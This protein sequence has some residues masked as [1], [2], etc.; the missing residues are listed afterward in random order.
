MQET[1]Q[2]KLNHYKIQQTKYGGYIPMQIPLVDLKANYLSIKK[3]IDTAIQKVL[4][5]TS[6]IN[7]PFLTEFE[8]NFTNFCKAKHAIGAANG[9]AALHLALL[10]AKIKPGDEIITV[11]N[12][13][14]ATTESISYVQGKI[15]F[16]DVR[17][18]T[19][20][21]N[22]NELKKNITKTTKA[23]IVVHLYGQMPDMKH[24]KEIATE[25][26]LFLIEDAAQAHAAEWNG[27]Q[28]G[29]YSDLATFSFFPAKNLGC[30]GDGG[31]IITNN[32][33][34]AE[35][36][37]L[38]LNHGRTQKYEHKIE[39]YNYRL[40]ALQAAIL[41]TKLPYLNKWT[42]Q[43]RKHAAY[44]NSHLPD[45][46]QTP[47]QAQNAKHVYYMYEIQAPDR[48][49]LQ[50]YLQKQNIQT[51]IHYPIP[52][53]LQPAYKKLGFKKESFPVSEKLAK[54]ILSLPMY[55]ELTETQQ[56]HVIDHINKFY[57]QKH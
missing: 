1:L 43:R 11:P 33:E 9:T 28:P 42:E 29:Y 31:A 25:H 56:N 48:D 6:F 8:R 34:I 23:I 7:G 22:I 39:G 19:A 16:V 24:I 18:D 57:K 14:I 27:H 37:R 44:Y 5:D 55:P 49:K 21:I 36:T 45:V 3:E 15:K 32:D 10:A 47:V 30:Y 52:L 41:N 13:F 46:I 26:D 38:L 12:T 2:K 40:D 35:Y 17:D 53:H 54:H 20:L 4:N 51:G 50:K